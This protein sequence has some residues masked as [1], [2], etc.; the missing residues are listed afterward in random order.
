ML[1][2]CRTILSAIS[3]LAFALGAAGCASSAGEPAV[4]SIG[5][6]PAGGTTAPAADRAELIRRY[7]DCMRQQGVL[8]LDTATE[9][10]LPQI[11]KRRTP[12]E[13]VEAAL[14]KCRAYL[15]T[16]DAAPPISPADL[17]AR[18]RHAACVRA[19]GVPDYPDPDS[20]TGEPKMSDELA[21][22]LKND[23]K[24]PTALEECRGL[25]PAP[26][27]TGHVGG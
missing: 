6:P 24:L 8:L 4:S 26:T 15:P 22:R 25:L 11:D 23:P 16:S 3:L 2:K 5:S 9:E 27:S 20:Q 21:G 13:K 14:R 12:V 19:H 7:A 1:T 10:G 18:Q 17:A